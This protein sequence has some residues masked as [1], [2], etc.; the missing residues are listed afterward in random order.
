MPPPLPHSSAIPKAVW[1]AVTAVLM[2]LSAFL[3]HL[4]Q[5]PHVAPVP[6]APRHTSEPAAPLPPTT[7]PDEIRLRLVEEHQ[8]QDA[9]DLND[10]AHVLEA[11][12][13]LLEQEL[14]EATARYVALAAGKHGPQAR[15]LFEQRSG[16]WTMCFLKLVDVQQRKPLRESIEI[17]LR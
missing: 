16:A 7:D 8:R 4:S 2:A 17:R 3:M 15:E 10:R 1:G 5:A 13:C 9:V 14:R 11:R 6:D 12:V